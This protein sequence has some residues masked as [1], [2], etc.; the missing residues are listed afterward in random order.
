MLFQTNQETR[1]AF[2]LFRQAFVSIGQWCGPF[3]RPDFIN[4]TDV[5]SLASHAQCNVFFA[6]PIRKCGNKTRQLEV[7][8]VVTQLLVSNNRNESPYAA[9]GPGFSPEAGAVFC[10]LRRGRR[11]ASSADILSKAYSYAGRVEN[12][13]SANGT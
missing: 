1:P 8:A 10:S 2:D 7:S 5:E 4:K 11:P 3:A 12:P 6:R 9:P 13:I